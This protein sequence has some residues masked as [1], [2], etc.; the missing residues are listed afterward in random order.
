[1]ANFDPGDDLVEHLRALNIQSTLSPLQ[2][3][4]DAYLPISAINAAFDRKSPPPFF[5]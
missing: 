5:S 4:P 1:M 3:I 2:W